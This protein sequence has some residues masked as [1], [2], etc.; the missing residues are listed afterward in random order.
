MNFTRSRSVHSLAPTADYFYGVNSK[1]QTVAVSPSDLVRYGSTTDPGEGGFWPDVTADASIVR[2]RDRLFVGGGAVSTGNFVGDQGGIV[3]DGTDGANWA[4]RDSVGFF[5]SRSGL[6]ALTG[7]ARNDDMNVAGGQPTETIGVSGFLIANQA[8]RGGWAGYLDVQFENGS[9]ALGLEIAIKNKSGSATTPTP[10]SKTTKL[11]AIWLPAGGDAS[12]GGSP[13]ANND[14]GIVFG[15]TGTPGTMSPNPTWNV[16]LLFYGD[17]L[18]RDGSDFATAIHLGEKHLI[19]WNTA[20]NSV[21]ASI[22]S[23]VNTG[24]SEVSLVAMNSK[25]LM[26]GPGSKSLVDFTS[27]AS[28]V[29]YIK[30]GNAV[31]G[32]PPFVQ[33]LGTDTDVDLRLITQAAGVVRFGTWTTNADAAVN[34]YVTIKDAAGNT[35]KLATI[36]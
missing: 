19:K 10:Y 29:N 33:A 11:A 20:G 17:S 36:A 21:G 9:G 24:S 30:L 6:M 22:W 26:R 18:T 16:G 31:T 27:V 23:E 13:N 35:R 8:T 12:Y 5:A 15:T 3:S 28:A 32:A 14:A 7:F 1:N 25:W 4:P 2:M 34:G